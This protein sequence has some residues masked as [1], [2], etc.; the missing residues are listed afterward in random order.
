MLP[1]SVYL[2]TSRQ[3]PLSREAEYEFF[4]GLETSNGTK[5]ATGPGR[6]AQID[7]L[8]FETLARLNVKPRSVMDIGISS[9]ITTA[10]WMNAFEARGQNV[11]MIA[12]DLVMNVYIYDLGKHLKVLTE[13]GGHLLQIELF[14]KGLRTYTRFRDYFLGGWIWR[15]IL[16]SYVRSR[17]S[18]GVRQGPYKLVSPSLRDRTNIQLLDDDI[19][20]PTP[21]E[22]LGNADVVRV[23]NLIQSVYFTDAQMK[24]AVIAV[25]ERCRGEGSLVVIC[26]DYK[27]RIEGSI[28]RLTGENRFVVEERIGGGS[29]AEPYFLIP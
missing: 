28:L 17:L 1:A 6:L 22:L 20:A 25:R 13:R 27:N 11:D 18:K 7:N 9:G 5:K 19:L 10:D 8:L 4:C 23:A 24:R 3:H 21:A 2:T 12:T 16:R 26:R 14:G 29:E 15:P